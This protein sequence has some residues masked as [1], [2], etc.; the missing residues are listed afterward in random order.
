[1]T[2]IR[3]SL[4]LLLYTLGVG[5]A[6]MLAAG[7]A[8]ADFEASLFDAAM[9]AE[10]QIT[11]LRCPILITGNETG[12]VVA[13][14]T[15]P[16]ARPVRR[17]I[18]VHV[19]DGFVTLMREVEERIVLAAGERRQ[20]QW[21]VTPQDAA[22]DRVI[23]VR[24]YVLRTYPLPSM[25]GA[26]GVLSLALPFLSGSQFTFLVLVA[27]LLSTGLGLGLW[28]GENRPLKK[29]GR[30]AAVA[31]ICLAGVGLASIVATL[32]GWWLASSVA[33]VVGVLLAIVLVTWALEAW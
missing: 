12:T 15:N 21:T 27:S 6:L 2:M 30:S 16:S 23:L 31:M 10:E 22:W 20:F 13:S 32:S 33:V 8:W 26:C 28:V 4:G 19:S 1:M 29:R 5:T 14:F 3:R 18:R 7:A 11:S 25:T 17:N 9:P 24:V